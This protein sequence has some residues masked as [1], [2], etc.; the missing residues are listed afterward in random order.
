MCG[1]HPQS[2]RLG[3]KY[4]YEG[5]GAF[6]A[7]VGGFEEATPFISVSAAERTFQDRAHLNRRQVATKTARHHRSFFDMT[8]FVDFL[9][10]IEL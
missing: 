4:R 10:D 7:W 9:D 2:L 8:S 6:R 3:Y 5:F 1:V